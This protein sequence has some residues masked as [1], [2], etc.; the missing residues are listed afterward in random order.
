MARRRRSSSAARRR[1]RRNPLFGKARRRTT[2]RRRNPSL[3]STSVSGNP[4]MIGVAGTLGGAGVQAIVGLLGT[5][6]G[7]SIWADIGRTAAATFALQFGLEKVPYTRK[8]AAAAALGG[9][10]IVGAKVVSAIKSYF[11]LSIPGLSGMRDIVQV[12]PASWDPYFGTSAIPGPAVNGGM[13]EIVQ[14]QR[15][16]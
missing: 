14:F 4:I 16:Y 10:F 15:G 5:I 3:T 1:T 2:R 12:Q 6:G 7:A 9:W 11:N 8:Y 13:A